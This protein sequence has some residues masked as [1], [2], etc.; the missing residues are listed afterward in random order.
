M[1]CPNCNHFVDETMKY[2]PGCNAE[3]IFKTITPILEDNMMSEEEKLP[4][5]QDNKKKDHLYIL[6]ISVCIFIIIALI[7]LIIYFVVDDKDNKTI[8]LPTT[9]T[10]EY[11]QSNS[12]NKGLPSTVSYPMKIGNITLASLYDKEENRDSVVD[13]RGLSFITGVNAASL[14]TNTQEVLYEDFVWEAIEIEVTLNDLDYLN[15]KVISPV[16]KGRVYKWHGSEY[17][18]H[19]EHFY[20]IDLIPLYTGE[21]IKNGENAKIIYLY[22]IP[23]GEKEYSLCFGEDTKTMGCFSPNV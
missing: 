16:I 14:A 10:K 17:I 3:L 22:Q 18:L 11:L 15:D 20:T 19:N 4:I 21:N 9:T 7:A 12:K 5:K 1:N 13:V 23:A 2:C 6:A 8:K